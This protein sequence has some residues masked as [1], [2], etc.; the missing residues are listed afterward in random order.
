MTDKQTAV[1]VLAR[2][3]EIASW[4]E[5][6]EEL[7][8]A[9]ALQQGQ[10]DAGRVRPHAEVEQA[11]AAEVGRRLKRVRQGNAH[12]TPVDEVFHDIHARH[13]G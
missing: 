12:G 2:L 3:P 8:V 1:E 5:N 4:E 10:A 11:R 6:T 9:A 13:Q 7:Q